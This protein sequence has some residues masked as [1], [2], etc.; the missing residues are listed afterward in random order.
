M[1]T[2]DGAVYQVTTR[3]IKK[4]R[5]CLLATKQGKGWGTNSTASEGR[6]RPTGKQTERRV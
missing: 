6:E 2:R 3:M 4:A 5:P 1:E